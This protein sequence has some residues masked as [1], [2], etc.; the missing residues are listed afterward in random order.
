M[1]RTRQAVTDGRKRGAVIGV[2]LFLMA[3][4][5]PG[6]WLGSY[7]ALMLLAHLTGGTAVPGGLT[8]AA[9]AAGVLTGAVCAGAISITGGSLAGAALA[10]GAALLR[11]S[12]RAWDEDRARRRKCVTVLPRAGLAADTE[13]EIRARSSFLDGF[14]GSL[15]SV[16]V[17]GSAAHGALDAGSDYD[18]VLICRKTGF[19]AVQNAVFEQEISD[20]L[21]CWGR[22]MEYTL[23]LPVDARRLFRQASPFAYAL[24]HGA[25]LYDDGFL[26]GLTAGRYDPSP[27][28]KFCLTALYENIV[29]AYY[30]SFC[31][32]EKDA[33]TKGCSSA[34]CRE[35]PICPGLSPAELPAKVIMRMLYVTLPARGAMPLNKGDVVAFARRIYGEESA[36]VV[37]RAVALGRSG[38]ESYRY[39]DHVRFKRLA[40]ALF[41]EIL[42]IV[43]NT[44]SVRG[45]LADAASIVQGRYGQ[46][47]DRTLRA[48]V[49]M[50]SNEHR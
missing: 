32:A 38:G 46:V 33:R 18:L 23:L 13:S 44:S 17:V 37:V 7:A 6:I 50:T 48:C 12:L 39:S 2:I 41:R 36:K 19:T 16:V 49:R 29:I 25:V 15:H 10:S 30:G 28:R 5:G 40:G 43:G 35:R 31:A 8:N 34:C 20:A 1:D 11:R 14:R 24:R 45:L 47:K 27:G 9:I 22:M 4:L 42:D 3:G 26:C 21:R